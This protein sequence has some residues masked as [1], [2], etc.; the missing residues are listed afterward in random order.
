MVHKEPGG[1][2][3]HAA[4]QQ[5]PVPHRDEHLQS[6]CV[7]VQPASVSLKVKVS[8][9]CKNAIKILETALG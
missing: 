1:D 9:L 6:P 3:Q 4:D 7:L 2:A 5:P 8:L